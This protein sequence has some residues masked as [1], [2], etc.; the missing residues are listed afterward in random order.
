MNHDA[1]DLDESRRREVGKV[2]LFHP[3]RQ[4]QAK[5]IAT[6]VNLGV[7][8]KTLSCNGNGRVP[9]NA[10]HI[11]PD[12][13]ENEKQQ[14]QCQQ[15][16]TTY[17]VPQHLS[18]PLHIHDSLSSSAKDL[19]AQMSGL[20]SAATKTALLI[21]GKAIRNI[22]H[23]GEVVTT[24]EIDDDDQYSHWIFRRHVGFSSSEGRKA[25]LHDFSSHPPRGA[26][27]NT[28]RNGN[29]D[30]IHRRLQQPSSPE[31]LLSSKEA[32]NLEAND[33]IT[34]THKCRAEK[35][36]LMQQL[37]YL[38]RQRWQ[39]ERSVVPTIHQHLIEWNARLC[40]SQHSYNNALSTSA[41]VRARRQWADEE[42]RVTSK[43]HV[44]GDMFLIWHRGP[45]AT[46]NGFR[47]GKSALTMA[48]HVRRNG[49][50][51]VGQP[52]KERGSSVLSWISSDNSGPARSN[53]SHNTNTSATNPH[54]IPEKVLIQWNEINSA[55]GQVLFL[56]YTLQNLSQ[57][58]ISFRRHV[59][60]PYGSA[61]KI[62]IIKKQALASSSAPSSSGK[63]PHERRT[64]TALAAYNNNVTIDA[65]HSNADPS[66]ESTSQSSRLPGDVTW[67]NLYHYEENGSL[68]SI[69]Y[70]AR[71]NFNIA[72]EGLL[73]CI[74]EAF[75]VVEDRDMALAAPYTM[76]IGGLIVGKD[77][78]DKE[79]V[80][81]GAKT[82][83]ASVGGIPI[84]YDPAK[85]E[86]WTTVCKYLLTNMKWLVSFAAKHVDR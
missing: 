23:R 1:D 58:G 9:T 27:N 68:L 82:S 50:H 44:L 64:I 15:I 42:I 8:D 41:E 66:S 59:L 67:Y 21:N 78:H 40:V 75:I 6:H 5:H 72:L 51:D 33:D 10:G 45:F 4:F 80:V 56:L 61:S 46:I 19:D 74:A 48:G 57:S 14:Q 26:I 47:L 32:K 53:A 69:G 85:G 65:Q 11:S 62:G 12:E 70:Y 30:N 29:Y 17:H 7:C 63:H 79:S 37:N 84:A 55:L 22:S 24:E 18:S 73:Y 36:E 71:R 83:E 86:E 20:Q 54:A 16:A 13:Y 52:G 28:Y 34:R 60:Q 43:C 25:Y 39:I 76:I 2:N 31:S 49:G 35:S 3:P 38:R 77:V 81:V